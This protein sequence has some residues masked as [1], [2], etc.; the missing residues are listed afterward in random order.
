MS[1]IGIIAQMDKATVVAEY[2]CEKRKAKNYQTEEELENEF[3]ELLK[4]Q[5]YEYLPIHSED[6]LVENLRTQLEKLNDYKFTDD[7]WE[8]FF[9]SEI[10][11]NNDGIVEKTR[12]I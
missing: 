7:E 12:T 4:G 8:R 5:S 3:I 9:T 6:E 2:E 1:K 11:N 10:A